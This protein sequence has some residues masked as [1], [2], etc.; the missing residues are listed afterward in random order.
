MNTRLC[1]RRISFDLVKQ[2]ILWVNLL[3]ILWFSSVRH[4]AFRMALYDK[5]YM[6]YLSRYGNIFYLIDI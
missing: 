5:S 3:K 2:Q 4:T 6:Y 1:S